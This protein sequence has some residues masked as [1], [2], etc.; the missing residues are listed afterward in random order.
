MDFTF[1]LKK[2]YE[3]VKYRPGK[4][5]GYESPYNVFK[6]NKKIILKKGVEDGE[7]ELLKGE[8]EI[9]DRQDLLCLKTML[10]LMKKQFQGK[11]LLQFPERA[12]HYANLCKVQSMP[13]N[14]GGP[15]E[16]LFK[17]ENA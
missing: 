14:I 12:A 1:S 17:N 11:W 5:V 3:L 6:S 4:M 13:T 2:F 16:G 10:W 15:M 8:I 7:I 9:Y